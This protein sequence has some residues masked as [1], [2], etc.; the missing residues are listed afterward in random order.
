VQVGAEGVGHRLLRAGGDLDRVLLGSQV[1][2]N[3]SLAIDLVSQR[4]ANKA[5]ANWQGLAVADGEASLGSMAVDELDAEDLGLRER[6]RDL[7]IEVGR[8]RLLRCLLDA[9]SLE[10]GLAG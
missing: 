9:L 5:D 8:L 2:D 1:A 6:D 10:R 7:D 3:L 4:A